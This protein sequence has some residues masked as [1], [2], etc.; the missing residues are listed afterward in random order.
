MPAAISYSMIGKNIKYYRKKKSIW[1]K[2]TQATL[3]KYT[4]KTAQY[5]SKVER[6]LVKPDLQFLATVADVLDCDVTD[7]L[8]NAMYKYYH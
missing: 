5:I 1:C 8:A 3:A 4:G 6:G 2:I 7:L